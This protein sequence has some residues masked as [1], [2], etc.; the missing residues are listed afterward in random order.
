MSSARSPVWESTCVSGTTYVY[1][2]RRQRDMS[3]AT[4]PGR[5]NHVIN[6]FLVFKVT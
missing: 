1:I 2:A 3:I 5:I 4:S 6:I